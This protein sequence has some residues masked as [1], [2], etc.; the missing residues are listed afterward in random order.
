MIDK[1][2]KINKSEKDFSQFFFTS[3][4]RQG[5]IEKVVVFSKTKRVNRWNLG[6]GDLLPTG[7]FDDEVVSNNGD[8]KKVIETV[9]LCAQIFLEKHPSASLLILPVDEKRRRL[10]TS[11]FKRRIKEIEANYRV[12]G[13]VG[14]GWKTFQI[15]DE[16]SMFEIFSKKIYF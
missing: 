14:S 3:E 8:L 7:D 13:W 12:F 9:A 2:Y 6:F 5:K 15:G 10:Y 11:I 1:A 16:P 4:G